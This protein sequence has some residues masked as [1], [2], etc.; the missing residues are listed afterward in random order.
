MHHLALRTARSELL[1]MHDEVSA[2]GNG[3][4]DTCIMQDES[5]FNVCSSLSVRLL[6]EAVLGVAVPGTQLLY[7]TK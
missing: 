5:P 1:A 3:K 2:Y 4:R 6:P 7:L